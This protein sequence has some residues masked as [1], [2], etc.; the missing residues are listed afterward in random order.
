MSA[1]PLPGFIEVE[2]GTYCNRQCAWCPNGWHDRGLEARSKSMRDETW[3]ALLDDPRWPASRV[4]SRSTT[5]TS[6]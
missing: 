2:I 1:A 5:T 6:R 3:R 4:G